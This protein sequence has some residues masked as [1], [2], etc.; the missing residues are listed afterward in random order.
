M[1]RFAISVRKLLT[2]VSDRNFKENVHELAI[3]GGADWCDNATCSIARPES[4]SSSKHSL[5]STLL[6]GNG[7]LEELAPTADAG[8]AF[9]ALTRSECGGGG[10]PQ[11]VCEARQAEKQSGGWET[12]VGCAAETVGGG[13]GGCTTVPWSAPV[14]GGGGGPNWRYETVVCAF[15]GKKTWG[16]LGN[17]MRR[18]STWSSRGLQISML[19]SR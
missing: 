11:D 3:W 5:G 6:L 9:C 19:P 4:W 8:A 16:S 10:A 7:H 14:D 2:S 18:P 12:D 15:C 1:R 17:S 13:G